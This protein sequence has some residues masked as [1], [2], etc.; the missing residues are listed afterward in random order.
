MCHYIRS[1]VIEGDATAAAEKRK[2]HTHPYQDK[3]F[4]F[5]AYIYF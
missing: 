1:V 2:A 3:P 4:I 5:L